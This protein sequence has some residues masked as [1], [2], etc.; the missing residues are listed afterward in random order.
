MLRRLMYLLAA[1]A[2]LAAPVAAQHTGDSPARPS[3][4]APKEA[5]QFAFLIGQWDLVVTPKVNSLAAKIHG[6]PKFLGTWK[7]WRIV[8][9]FGV[10]DE[11]RIVDRSGNPSSLTHALRV[12][13][14]SGAKWLITGVDAYRGTQSSSSGTFVGGE[15]VINGQ[16][17]DA[18]GKPTLTRTR[19]FA[20]TPTTFKYQ[21]DRSSDNG[22]TWD[23]AVLK[24]EAK[25]TAA[26]AAR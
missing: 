25:R 22:R 20:I 8:D 23:E 18:E 24:I 2:T 14:A 13:S 6:S 26:V 17:T 7:A 3:P 16:S 5:A 21:Q 19:Y 9:G 10:E 4:T 11:L 1:A 15:M 12:Y